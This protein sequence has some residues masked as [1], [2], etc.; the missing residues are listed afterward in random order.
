MTDWGVKTRAYQGHDMSWLGSAMHV[1]A[2]QAIELDLSLFDTVTAF[3]NG[4]L[5]PGIVL[6]RRASDNIV[7]PYDSGTGEVNE[8]QQVAIT[9]T[10]TG[11][12]FTLSFA[13]QTTAAIPYNATAAQVVTALEALSNVNSGDVTATGGALPG[14][15]VVVEFR[16]QYQDVNV[17]QMTANGAALTG[18][19][20]PAVAITTAGAG[21]GTGAATGGSGLDVPVGHL[22]FPVSTLDNYGTQR[23][24]GAA[25]ASLF[26]RGRVR[27]PNLPANS[28]F[29]AAC[30]RVLTH[31]EYLDVN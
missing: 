4:F 31:I 30:R 29:D 22:L 21:G 23:T 6:A 13:G 26:T 9:G 27:V 3:P 7:G 20:S 25:T 15:P 5:P 12:T 19:S 8:T 18:G 24:S 14:T 1:D 17:A 2:G 11:G 10:P 28:G 16:G